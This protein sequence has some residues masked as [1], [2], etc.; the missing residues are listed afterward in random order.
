VGGPAPPRRHEEERE[1]RSGGEFLF[2]I[3]RFFDRGCKVGESNFSAVASFA[4]TGQKKTSV[5]PSL[6]KTAAEVGRLARPRRD[7]QTGVEG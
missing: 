2:F 7:F 6:G 4:L 5:S 1:R 3:V